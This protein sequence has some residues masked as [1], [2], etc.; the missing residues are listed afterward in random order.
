MIGY[1]EFWHE[2]NAVIFMAIT[3]GF[4]GSAISMDAAWDYC[5][6]YFPNIDFCSNSQLVGVAGAS[7][8]PFGAT[9]D[10]EDMTVIGK[11]NDDQYLDYYAI[12][13]YHDTEI[14]NAD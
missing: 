4:G 6:T 10:L 5:T 7:G 11:E 9:I 14:A 13:M 3:S 12:D 8:V 1:D 2:E